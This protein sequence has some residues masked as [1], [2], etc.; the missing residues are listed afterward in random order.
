VAGR[1]VASEV[2]LK[3]MLAELQATHLKPQQRLFILRIHL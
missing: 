1:E 3:K 2:E